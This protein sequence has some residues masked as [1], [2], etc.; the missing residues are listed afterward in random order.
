MQ[1]KGKTL[2]ISLMQRTVIQQNKLYSKEE[3]RRRILKWRQSR[4]W[5]SLLDVAYVVKCLTLSRN[6]EII[7][8]DI[9]SVHLMI[10]YVLMCITHCIRTLRPRTIP[11]LYRKK[12]LFSTDIILL[13]RVD[14]ELEEGLILT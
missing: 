6:F 2:A 10:L 12:M 14:E 13:F 1:T 9:V 4:F 3:Y 11:P 5:R 7:A 8:L